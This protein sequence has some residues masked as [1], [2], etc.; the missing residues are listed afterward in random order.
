MSLLTTIQQVCRRIGITAP[1]T[2]SG[3]NDPQI[4]QLMAIGNEEGQDLSARYP[5]TVLQNESTFTTVAVETQGAIATLAGAD[6]RYILN[7]IMWNRSL[8][9]P[10]F[11]PL[12]PQD[13]QALKARNVTGPYT[14]FRI[15]G[16]SVLF[17]PVPVAGNTI[18]FEWIS[19][20][21]VTVAA[22]GTSATWTADADTGKTDEEIMAQGVLWRWKASKGI[23]YAEDFNKYERLVAD[24]MA[25]DGGK[26]R[27]NLGGGM[28]AFAAGVLVPLGS[29]NL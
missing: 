14:Q 1:L 4:I 23:E 7:D 12:V 8:L 21:W 3:S 19:K 18:A 11:G 9:R 22:G 25:R 29:W 10:V 17:I 6:F 24:Q 13:W 26:A 27:L 5:W 15:R 2:V 28:N 20:N 16:T